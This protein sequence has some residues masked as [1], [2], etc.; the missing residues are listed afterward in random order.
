MKRSLLNSSGS[1]RGS[2]FLTVMGIIGV[3]LI[4][5]VSMTLMTGNA[6][7]TSRNLYAAEQALAI[8]ESGIADMIVKMTTN[9]IGWMQ[10]SNT[11]SYA[12]GTYYVVTSVDTVTAHV[13]ISSEGIFQGVKRHTTLELLGTLWDLYDATIGVDGCIICGGDATLE[14]SAMT[15]NGGIH[16]NGDIVNTT[17]NPDINGD[18]SAGGTCDV[19]VDASHTVTTN[20][21]PVVVPTYLPLD[22]WKALAQAGGLYYTN[23]QVF[24]GVNLLPSNGVIYVEGSVEIANQSSMVGTLVASQN[25]T[26]N[27][28]FD[29]TPF[30]TNWPCLLAGI[31]VNLF[32][33]NTYYGVI[34]AGNNVTMRNRR[35]IIGAVIALNDVLVEN[36]A[37]IDP[38]MFTPAWA[39][40]D[41]NTTPPSVLVG[42][43]LE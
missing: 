24:G 35:D 20:A 41:T 22:P 7:F 17:G 21:A 36:G 23:S 16:A 32:N 11:A 2:A 13:V 30:N 9:Y 10:A 27:N 34:F 15:V 29:Q 40:D 4:A 43:W 1:R 28:R 3:L 38:L 33:R 12:G 39:P 8:A 26:I 6:A 37:T 25:I 31:D 18:V 19:T 5:G 14:T 42:G